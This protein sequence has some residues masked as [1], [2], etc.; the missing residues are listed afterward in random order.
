MPFQTICA[1]DNMWK[2]QFYFPLYTIKFSPIERCARHNKHFL[3]CFGMVSKENLAIFIAWV[4]SLFPSVLR[5]ASILGQPLADVNENIF[6]IS[7]VENAWL[8]GMLFPTSNNLSVS[9]TI[10]HWDKTSS[11]W[12][13][14]NK[15]KKV[16]HEQQR[17]LHNSYMALIMDPRLLSVFSFSK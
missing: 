1:W 17:D 7:A 3:H 8:D 2:R 4:G 13:I 11:K 10:F 15:W 6:A 9:W 14:R 12:R 16:F 5:E